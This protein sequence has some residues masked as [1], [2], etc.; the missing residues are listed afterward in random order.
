VRQVVVSA[1]G[2]DRPGI[3]ASVTGAL[4]EHEVNIDDSNMGRLSG[5]FSMM[6]I[7]TAPDGLD[8]VRLGEDLERSAAGSGLDVIFAHDV[9]A[10]AEALEPT[11]IVTLY[12]AD[13]PGIVHAVA[14]ALAR[15][16]AN[17]I[18]LETRVAGDLY[19]MTLDV[20]SDTDVEETLR[21]VAAEQGVELTVRPFEAEI[22]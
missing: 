19:V 17:I 1:L 15:R 20:V 22:L 7:C 10:G 9:S 18:D 4:L 11:H 12:G 13:H 6:L 2:P 5:R 16:G 21:P 3:V 8:L 14:A